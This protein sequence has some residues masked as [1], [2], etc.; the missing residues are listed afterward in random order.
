MYIENVAS[1]TGLKI[2]SV[3]TM[4]G[5]SKGHRKKAEETGD[6]SHI[7]PGDMPP[8][9]GK[10]PRWPYSPWWYPETITTWWENRPGAYNQ[11]WVNRNRDKLGKPKG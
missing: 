11:D 9:D 7:R 8:E 3:R 2:A 6:Q 10:E 4:H 5:R 1:Y